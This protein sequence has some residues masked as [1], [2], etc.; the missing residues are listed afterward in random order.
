[1]CTV[2]VISIIVL[3][4]VFG[5]ALYGLIPLGLCIA[6]GLFLWMKEVVRSGRSQEWSSERERGQMVGYT[7]KFCQALS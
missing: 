7:P 5:G 1:M 3:G 6:S 4:K 2:V